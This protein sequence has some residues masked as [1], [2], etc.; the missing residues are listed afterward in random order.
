MYNNYDLD[1]LGGDF[2][3]FRTLKHGGQDDSCMIQVSRKGLFCSAYYGMHDTC[4]HA[5][6]V[7]IVLR[8]LSCMSVYVYAAGIYT[9]I[10]FLINKIVIAT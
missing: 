6:N 5:H 10:F 7:I 8:T 3:R 2:S 4:T 1:F 9:F